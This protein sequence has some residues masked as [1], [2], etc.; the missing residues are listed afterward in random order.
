[1]PMRK[2]QERMVVVGA[3]SVEIWRGS[4]TNQQL[5]AGAGYASAERRK[6]A[7]CSGENGTPRYENRLR[8]GRVTAKHH[9]LQPARAAGAQCLYVEPAAQAR[10]RY[11]LWRGNPE[12]EGEA[13]CV[14]QCGMRAGV[15]EGAWFGR[16]MLQVA[17]TRGAWCNA[18][19]ASRGAQK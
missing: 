3:S 13:R 11:D 10:W 15:K 7:V 4:S 12:G 8:E 6:Q 14:R 1:M 17:N 16:C 9:V 18:R 19:N 5:P 2:A